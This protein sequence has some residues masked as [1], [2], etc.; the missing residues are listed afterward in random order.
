MGSNAELKESADFL[1]CFDQNC[2]VMPIAVTLVE[3]LCS[4]DA[5]LVDE[6]RA[7]MWNAVRE[8][9]SLLLVADSVGVNRFAAL[10]R[11]QGKGDATF[12]GEA[13]Q[14]EFRIVTDPD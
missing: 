1:R 10:V 9:S 5:L 11:K 7:R 6:E 14:D 4:N 2:A 8:L 13:F 12:S 3:N